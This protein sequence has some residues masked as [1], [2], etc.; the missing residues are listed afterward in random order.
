MHGEE[1]NSTE[2]SV[3]CYPSTA[4][5]TPAI[6]ER[7]IARFTRGSR[8][9]EEAEFTPKIPAERINRQVPKPDVD[10]GGNSLNPSLPAGDRHRRRSQSCPTRTG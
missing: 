8:G 9:Q 5:S 4:R 7:Y 3:V 10:V 1:R 6:A 2:I